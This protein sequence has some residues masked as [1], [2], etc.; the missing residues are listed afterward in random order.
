MKR[1][2]TLFLIAFAAATFF[3]LGGCEKSDEKSGGPAEKAGATMGRAVDQAVE[4]AGPVMEKAG[5][6][7]KEV[8]G[9]AKEEISEAIENMRQGEKTSDDKK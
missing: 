3:S 7:L 2:S 4:K 8:G 6:A 5:K 9:K 1:L